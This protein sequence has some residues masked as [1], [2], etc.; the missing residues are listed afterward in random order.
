MKHFLVYVLGFTPILL[1]LIDTDGMSDKE[2][3][4]KV[5]SLNNAEWIEIH[6]YQACLNKTLYDIAKTAFLCYN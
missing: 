6:Y 2:I 1:S 5:A 4:D 3:K